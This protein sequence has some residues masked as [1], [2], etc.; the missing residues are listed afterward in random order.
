MTMAEN[1]DSNSKGPSLSLPQGGGAIGGIG[2]TFQADLFSGTGNFSIPLATSPGRDGF[3]PQ[4]VL[5]YNSGHGN[6][7]F[8]LGWRHTV[9]RV[10]RKTEKGLPRYD[11]SDGFILSGAEDLVPM[12]VR[13]G[14]QWIPPAPLEKRNAAGDLIYRVTRYRPRTEGLFARIERWT[15][16][17]GDVHWR[18]TTKDNLTNIYGKTTAARI[19]DPDDPGRVYEWLLEESFDAKGNHMLY[20]YAAEGAPPISHPF[21]A[22]RVYAQKYLRRILYGN[23]SVALGPQRDG[24]RHDAPL[25]NVARRYVFEVVFD[26]GDLTDLSYPVK[27]GGVEVTSAWP[28]R[29]DPFSTFRPGFELR[30]LRRCQRVLMFHHFQE[31]QQPTLV[32][33]TDFTHQQNA[34][35]S[36][37]QLTSVVARSY[38]RVDNVYQTAA[39]PSLSFRYSVFEPT[40]QRYQSLSVEDDSLPPAALSDAN[41]ALVDL[42]GDGMPDVLE[43]RQNYYRYWRNL[44]NGNFDRPHPMHSSPAGITLSQDGVAIT[45]M[46]GNG[47]VDLLTLEP[48]LPGF[49]ESDQDEAWLRF[50]PFESSPTLD[51]SD[52]NTRQIDLTGDGLTDVLVTRDHHFLWFRN[53]GEEGYAAPKYVERIHD[54]D[55]FPDVYFDDRTR[56]VRLADMTGDGLADIVLLHNGRVDYWPN[57]GYGRFGRRITMSDAPRLDA[58]F[59]PARLHLVDIDGSGCNDLVYVD[60]C[61]VY[62]WFNQCGNRWGDKQTI[63]G[64]PTALT[65]DDVRFADVFGTGTTSLVWSYNST[66]FEDRNYKVLDFCGGR[67]PHLLVEMDNHMG[68]ITRVQYAPSTKFFLEDE[69]DTKT[70][71]IT[72]LPFPV[73]VIERSEVVDHIS[74]TKLISC[75]HYHHGYYDGREREFRGF[76][77]VDQLDTETFDTFATGHLHDA[78]FTPSN[79][80]AAFHQPPVLTKNWFH[81]GIFYRDQDRQSQLDEDRLLH[82]YRQE[83]YQADAQAFD[84]ERSALPKTDKPHEAARALRGSRLRTEVYALDGSDREDHPYSTEESR[85]RVV[86]VQP[87]GTNAHAVFMTVPSESLSYSYERQADDPSITQQ[88]TLGVD[89]HGNVTDTVA[90]AY[91]RRDIQARVQA[92]GGLSEDAQ[93]EDRMRQ[94]L[95]YEQGRFDFTYAQTEYVRPRGEDGNDAYIH[96]LV[97]ETR[98]YELTGVPAPQDRWYT[99]QEIQH[100]FQQSHPIAYHARPAAR[101]QQHRLVEHSRQLYYNDDASAGRPLR[102]VGAHGLPFRSFQLAFPSTHDA[103]GRTILQS[104][105]NNR[106][107]ARM[108]RQGG[109]YQSDGQYWPRDTE[110]WIP[111][112]YASFDA[113][114]FFRIQQQY[115]PFDNASQVT[116]DAYDLLLESITDPLGNQTSVQDEQGAVRNNYRVLLPEA[117]RDPNDNVT[118]VLFDTLGLVIATAVKGKGQQ[119][120]SI[121]GLVLEPNRAEL[122]DPLAHEQALLGRA[123]T[124]ILYDFSS[125]PV[126]THS[127]GR[128]THDADL[129][130]GQSTRISHA[131]VYSDGLGRQLQAKAIAESGPTPQRDAETGRIVVNE[132]VV[133]MNNQNNPRWIV[134]GWAVVNNK[135]NVVQQFEPFFSDRIE[136]ERDVRV[137]TSSTIF[138]DPLER[139]IATIYPNHTFEKFVFSPWQRETWDPNDTALLHPANDADIGGYVSVFLDSYQH[140][141]D[142]R[143]FRTWYD[144]RIADRNNPPPINAAGTTAEQRAA[145]KAQAHAGTPSVMH[146]DSLGREILMVA[147]NGSE[148]L[149]ALIELDIEGNDLS[150][151][152]ARLLDGNLNAGHVD[153]RNANQ[154][155]ASFRS[156]FDAA[157]RR[158]WTRSGDYGLQ[159]DLQDVQG[160]PL[161]SWDANGN[162]SYVTYDNAR[163]PIELWTRNTANAGALPPF[164][165][166]KRTTYGDVANDVVNN[167]RGQVWRVYDG[168]GRIENSSFDFKGNLTRTTRT[169]LRDGLAQVSWGTNPS[170]D[171]HLF[172][173]QDVAV[174]LETNGYTIRTSYDAESRIRTYETPDG[175]MQRPEYNAANLL[176]RVTLTR[177]N[178]GGAGIVE[179]LVRNI[180]YDEKGRRSLVEYGNG[181]TTRYS[182]DPETS[183][184]RRL[185]SYRQQSTAANPDLQDLRYTYD[186]VGNVSEIHDNAQAAIFHAN[187]QVDPVLR[188]RYDALYRL[189][190]ATG[191]E[192][193]LMSACHYRNQGRKFTEFLPVPQPANNAQAV[194]NYRE[195]FRYDKS[196]NLLKLD[197][198]A[199]QAHWSRVQAYQLQCN[200]LLTSRASCIWEDA[201]I[202]HDANGNIAGLPHVPGMNWDYRNLLIEAQLNYGRNPNRAFYQYDGDGQR[203]RKIVVNGGV[204]EERVYVG[205]YEV[206]RRFNGNVEAFRRETVHVA[207]DKTRIALIETRIIDTQNTEAG[208]VRRV[209][210]Q[211]GN[212]LGSV[213]FELDDSVNARLVSYEE[214]YPFGGSS[215]IAGRS[216]PASRVLLNR[217]RYRYHG[218]ERDDETGFYYY[219]ARYCAP[220]MG[221]WLSPDPSGY[222]GGGNL[223]AFVENNPIKLI[224]LEGQRPRLTTW[225]LTGGD[226]WEASP[227]HMKMVLRIDHSQVFESGAGYQAIVG[228][229]RL[230][231]NVFFLSYDMGRVAFHNDYRE[232]SFATMVRAVDQNGL[233]VFKDGFVA[234]MDA[235]GDGDAVAFGEFAFGTYM[236]ARNLANVKPTNSTTNMSGGNS[237][238]P[239]LAIAGGGTM[240]PA[241]ALEGGAATVTTYPGLVPAA[242]GSTALMMSQTKPPQNKGFP[243][244]PPPGEKALRT[245]QPKARLRAE[246]A[247]VYEKFKAIGNQVEKVFVGKNHNNYKGYFGVY[248]IRIDG[249][250]FK[251][252]KADMTNMASTGNPARLQSQI[253]RLQKLLP[254]R[255]V[256]GKVLVKEKNITVKDIKRIETNHIQGHV[257]KHGELPPGNPD[258]PGI[259]F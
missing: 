29:P 159:Q 143:G 45:D 66:R 86:E 177:P 112:G 5:Q 198:T 141:L 150:Y 59:D 203:V 20:E 36:M 217:K 70:R 126:F 152:D 114:S 50:Q 140:H 47:Q 37:S 90:I 84:L 139:N 241:L 222:A 107:S 4:L 39:M 226:K 157:G 196:G 259:I 21:E 9:P 199:G 144:E 192:H 228:C 87:A 51:L 158:S 13:A 255:E 135:G 166:V 33:S 208:P 256:S 188:Y 191:R 219:G 174:L 10:T 156:R 136:F 94:I 35:T 109:Y 180:E 117:L 11:E 189:V 3:G 252:G 25:E 163:R 129:A 24:T 100:A 23:S 64:T 253:N 123:T 221:R 42:F 145:L 171:D 148:K 77:R 133:A 227:E 88:L 220:W 204:T 52:P 118:E 254:D 124:R 170:P 236:M 173:P 62:F 34:D 172:D 120:D 75:Y 22:H 243:D 15:R 69:K 38:Q 46:A 127:L 184:L 149:A 215:F 242:V 251:Y 19:T 116:Y 195:R 103:S 27:Q 95:A 18:V 121:S 99:A 40:K 214:Y 257:T 249:K 41:Y 232:N 169:L 14:N 223:Y 49:Y 182:Y 32:K 154:W 247:A 115:D 178:G 161:Y 61:A 142:R 165:L 138:Y 147:D 235:I 98:T 17:D 101:L 105:F 92:I 68:A 132:G 246:L 31:L 211:L 2:E 93:R 206:Y 83:F 197:H 146:L 194:R 202:P 119:G 65:A 200:R 218:K 175:A 186:P 240:T 230:V 104:L 80:N 54:L 183:F 164:S 16:L 207:D 231:E 134:G 210:Y 237:M 234:Q 96:S 72:R 179:T 106:V 209:R 213:S 63:V 167:L 224:D 71:W 160:Q 76:G 60:G 85:F 216:D 113:A 201:P 78:N 212:H 155:D 56:R 193:E 12:L 190:E 245:S 125:T 55:A 58:D 128:H 82:H 73:Q 48:P 205:E 122:D 8:G 239:A 28:Q 130:A 187:Q 110:W 162:E 7:P 244:K 97:C 6:G 81:N 67:K 168:A 250:L 43:T 89:E 153:V 137:G 238:T 1:A 74:G 44:G 131:R 185:L 26:Y 30:T 248:E 102:E 233:D 91:P 181:V 151:T 108:L 176:Q 79:S 111:S 258:H 225:L 57:L 53:L 229:V